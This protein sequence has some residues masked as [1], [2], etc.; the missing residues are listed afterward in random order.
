[1]ASI[2]SPDDFA[3]VLLAAIRYFE[4]RLFV[5]TLLLQTLYQNR[6]SFFISADRQWI[7]V[8]RHLYHHVPDESEQTVEAILVYPCVMHSLMILI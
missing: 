6:L 4:L 2:I 5:V 1:M 3:A 8:I 7:T